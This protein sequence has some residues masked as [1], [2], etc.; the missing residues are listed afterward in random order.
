MFH[1]K[2]FSTTK[3]LFKISCVGCF[4]SRKGSCSFIHI[5]A[6]TSIFTSRVSSPGHRI[7]AV[8]VSVCV[9]LSVC[10]HSHSQTVWPMTLI[11]GMGRDLDLSLDNIVGQGR[12]SRSPGKISL[13]SNLA[14]WG[15]VW[16]HLSDISYDVTKQYGVLTP[17]GI[18]LCRHMTSHNDLWGKRTSKCPTREVREHSS[19]FI[20]G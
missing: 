20:Q 9:C 13:C 11:F 3:Y 2:H 1:Q 19:V 10:E 7:G 5:H 6:A 18:T 8:Y 12:R 16:S 15:D 17:F 4:E 14:L